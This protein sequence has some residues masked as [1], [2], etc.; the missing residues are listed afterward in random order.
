MN[1]IYIQHREFISDLHSSSEK[2]YG[3]RSYFIGDINVRSCTVISNDP[4]IV[5]KSLLIQALNSERAGVI[6]VCFE[7]RGL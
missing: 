4:N 7:W 5:R 2:P 3:P 1:L 6:H